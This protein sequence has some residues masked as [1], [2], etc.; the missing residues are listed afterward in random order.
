MPYYGY[1]WSHWTYSQVRSSCDQVLLLLH[2]KNQ[3]FLLYIYS[4]ESA[5]ARIRVYPGNIYVFAYLCGISTYVPDTFESFVPH[6]V[7]LKKEVLV[8]L[9]VFP[10]HT[11]S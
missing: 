1:D 3:G 9:M 6:V 7:L 10:F 2:L 5:S 11:P 8:S 4:N